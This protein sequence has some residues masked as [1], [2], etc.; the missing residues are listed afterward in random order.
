MGCEH[1]RL[2]VSESFVSLKDL[3][4]AAALSRIEDCST[5]VESMPN[6]AP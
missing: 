2:R 6:V 4:I 5:T 3:K 1:Y